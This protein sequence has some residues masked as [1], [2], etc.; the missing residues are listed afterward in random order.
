[1]YSK[2]MNLEKLKWLIIWDG[3]SK[4]YSTY[5]KPQ[6]DEIVLWIPC[7]VYYSY[8]FKLDDDVALLKMI[9]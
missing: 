2:P 1:M 8:L 6:N 5:E 7:F 4:R 9:R 3:E